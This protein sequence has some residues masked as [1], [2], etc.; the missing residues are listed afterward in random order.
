MEKKKY[1]VINVDKDNSMVTYLDDGIKTTKTVTAPADIKFARLGFAEIG[2]DENNYV[3]FIRSEKKNNSNGFKPKYKTANAY[4]KPEEKEYSKIK[5]FRGLSD[6]EL[7]QVYNDLADQYKVKA[8]QSF[9]DDENKGL[10]K[11]IIYYS[12]KESQLK[13]EEDY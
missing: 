12:I 1:E 3:N 9:E 11:G 10:W 13:N 4:E 5:I 2:F 7:E 6:I 8:T